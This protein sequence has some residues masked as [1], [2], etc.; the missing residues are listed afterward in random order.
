MSQAT[1]VHYTAV[2]PYKELQ[3]IISR[4]KFLVAQLSSRKTTGYSFGLSIERVLEM[5]DEEDKG[6]KGAKSRSLK[7]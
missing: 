3:R 5:A 4:E 2:N 1:R 7:K 6:R